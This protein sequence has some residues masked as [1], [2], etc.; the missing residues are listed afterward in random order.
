[1]VSDLFS[2]YKNALIIIILYVGVFLGLTIYFSTSETF[3]DPFDLTPLIPSDDLY[4]EVALIFLA[5]APVSALI[6]GLL[7]G[8]ILAP[9]KPI[10]PGVSI[11]N[12]VALIDRFVNQ[13]TEV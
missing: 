12:A 1:M 5:I 2:R 8:Y 4:V 6:G 13:K 10:L 11:E 3:Q 9:A 7:G